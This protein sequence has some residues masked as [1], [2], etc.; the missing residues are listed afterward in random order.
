MRDPNV[1]NKSIAVQILVPFILQ[2]TTFT[3]WSA[4]LIIFDIIAT[5]SGI[6]RPICDRNSRSSRAG[7]I[8]TFIVGMMFV[9]CAVLSVLAK[10]GPLV[11]VISIPWIGT[12]LLVE[13]IPA[14]LTRAIPNLS[15]NCITMIWYSRICWWC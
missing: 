9:P 14:P 10:P 8:S 13:I 1:K 4:Q 7:S 5:A 2:K 3:N 6:F 11:E 15:E 12:V